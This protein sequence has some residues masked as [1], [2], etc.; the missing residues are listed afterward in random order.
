[1][2]RNACFGSR[3]AKARAS[4]FGSRR[5][6][7]RASTLGSRRARARASTWGLALALC[8]GGCGG[9]D[10]GSGN[11]QTQDPAG[12]DD[13]TDSSGDGDG[14]SDGDD[15][16]D[17]SS[18][19]GDGDGD[20]T[21]QD[22]DED[23]MIGYDPPDA[24]PERDGGP[25]DIEPPTRSVDCGGSE[26]ETTD[27]RVCCEGWSIDT[28]FGAAMC[29]SEAACE[30]T[31]ADWGNNN[32][33]VTS[34]CDGGD[35]CAASQVC[36]FF[37]YG[38]DVWDLTFTKVG[39]GAGRMCLA[40]GDCNAEF[41]LEFGSPTG[42]VACTKDEHCA[43]VGGTCQPEQSGSITTGKNGTARPGVKVCR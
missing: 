23:G 25:I 42:V 20:G 19:D 39:P 22:D 8:L 5:A 32:R 1:M 11:D 33:K 24:G 4:T 18:G 36:C 27:N 40:P 17:E 12:S 31:Y 21:T 7:A 41:T 3:R 43:D 34:V 26:C 30:N 2:T 9:G 37:I 6:K 10:S 14:D 13:G 15:S 16:A 38:M 35:D 28:G 29:T